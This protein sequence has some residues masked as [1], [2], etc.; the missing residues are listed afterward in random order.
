MNIQNG[1]LYNL[2]PAVYRQKDEDLALAAGEEK[3]PLKA[4]MEL[5]EEQVELL[6]NNLDQ[7]YND[8]FI[9]TCS[10]WV[11]PYIGEIVGVKN[12]YNIPGNPISERAQVANTLAYRRRKGTASVIE[13]LAKDITGWPANVTEYFKLLATTQYMNHIRPENISFKEIK[14]ASFTKPTLSPFNTDAHTIDV[15]N[16][17]KEKGKYNIQN[18]GIFLWRIA[19]HSVTKG[20]A[21][22]VD[23][24][25]FKFNSTGKDT[26]LY[27][28]PLPEVDISYTAASENVPMPIDR[29]SFYNNISKFYGKGK[30]V[31][32]YDI[33]EEE[34]KICNLSDTE[35]GDWANTPSNKIAIDPVLGRISFPPGEAPGFLY[36]D[37]YYGFAGKIGAGEYGRD[38][39]SNDNNLPL[40]R[41][42]DDKPTLQEAVNELAET[43]GIIELTAN[44]YYFETPV[45][46]IEEGKYLEIRAA[47]K[48]MPLI[49]LN[50]TVSI[51]ANENSTLVFN[52]LFF[53]G[54]G[55]HVPANK[56][57]GFLNELGLLELQHCTISP[58][59]SLEIAGNPAQAPQPGIVI[60]TTGTTCKIQ[61]SIVSPI[62]NHEINFCEISNSILDALDENEWAY[63]GLEDFGGELIIKNS[64]IIGRVATTL[65]LL[66]E[67]SIFLAGNLSGKP[68]Q[69]QRLQ[70]GCMRFSYIP[71]GSAVPKKYKC[72]PEKD[73]ASIKTRPIFNSLKFSD[74]DYCQLHKHCAKEILE[75]AEKG[76]EMGVYYNHFQPMKLS[77]LKSLLNEYLRFGMEAG[78]FFGS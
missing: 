14:K 54:G 58:D 10:N 32:L 18:I 42:P 11:V 13:Q 46:H 38:S 21:Y 25:R 77:S 15:R 49:V 33:P 60:E 59:G 53:T 4:F 41:V 27:N 74:A 69:A 34:I 63:K 48:K 23:N 57:G 78:I 24:N 75:G 1:K 64:T 36:T 73:L 43:G 22:K 37:Y 52:G 8:Q 17:N 50:G 7:L 2:I 6:E 62:I 40:I 31:W 35:T 20:I 47:E 72:Q 12:L 19:S 3:G 28:N 68:I 71:S 30:S 26:T 65:F 66:A 29:I 70:E 39:Y 56:P 55:L 9:E 76:A 44:D 16:I 45:I 67:N 5:L 51:L 61:N